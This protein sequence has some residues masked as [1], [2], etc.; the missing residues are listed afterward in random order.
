M[1][2][3]VGFKSPF[4]SHVNAEDRRKAEAVTDQAGAA[5]LEHEAGMEHQQGRGSLGDLVG[6][7][8]SIGETLHANLGGT[9]AISNI[10]PVPA[11]YKDSGVHT[12]RDPTTG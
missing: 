7:G 5:K 9:S 2:F 12:G 6:A 3:G 11:A 10:A 4:E 1:P 8:K